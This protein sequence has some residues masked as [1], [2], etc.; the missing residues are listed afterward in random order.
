[1]FIITV[2]FKDFASEDIISQAFER[3][4]PGEYETIITNLQ[5]GKFLRLNENEA[6]APSRV[7]GVT[8]KEVANDG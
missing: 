4:T 6:V 3:N 7:T 2:Y 1:M 8:V 5:N